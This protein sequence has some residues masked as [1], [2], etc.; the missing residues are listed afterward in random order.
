MKKSMKR[1][2]GALLAGLCVAVGSTP[3]TAGHLVASGVNAETGNSVSAAL[4]FTISGNVLTLVLANTTAGGTLLRGDILTGVAFNVAG[5][6]PT[7]TLTG[8]TLTDASDLKFTSKTGPGTSTAPSLSNFST[9][10]G[11]SPISEFGLTVTGF[12]GAFKNPSGGAGG[13]NG[14]VADGT[15]PAPPGAG[16]SNSFKTAFPL[17]ENSLTFTFAITGGLTDS[18]IED[19]KF[20]FGTSGDGVLRGHRVGIENAVPE[21]ASIVSGGLAMALGGI[22]IVVRRRRRGH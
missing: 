14:I 2:F 21:P 6:N 15:F 1:L 17:Y 3:A 19:V 16:T 4:D 8:V 5:A 13:K 7:L 10:L 18:R 22:G 12:D 9:T 20:L 11:S